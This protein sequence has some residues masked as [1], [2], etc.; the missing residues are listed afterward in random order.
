MAIHLKI[1]FKD[2]CSVSRAPWRRRT[3]NSEGKS[4]QHQLLI[5]LALQT[6]RQGTSLAN[7]DSRLLQQ[8]LTKHLRSFTSCQHM[9]LRKPV[10]LHCNYPEEVFNL[11]FKV[12]EISSTCYKRRKNKFIATGRSN[13][14][15]ILP[16]LQRFAGCQ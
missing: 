9:T 12:H 5:L 3:S 1:T 15:Y 4:S 13:T 6:S 14:F 8:Y 2:A 7:P 10:I 16:L 11:N